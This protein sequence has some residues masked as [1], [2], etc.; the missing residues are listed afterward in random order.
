[1]SSSLA[2]VVPEEAA[3]IRGEWMATERRTYESAA[4]SGTGTGPFV[5]VADM[6]W[7][8][9]IECAVPVAGIAFLVTSREIYWAKSDPP[10]EN[11]PVE[12]AFHARAGYADGRATFA[13]SLGGSVLPGVPVAFG[14]DVS[15][16]CAFGPRRAVT[17][18]AH[19]V[20]QVENVAF[21]VVL[22][23]KSVIKIGRNHL[24]R[25]RDQLAASLPENA[26]RVLTR[27]RTGVLRG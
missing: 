2:A 10:A 20:A 13:A 26:R 4:Q 9:A 22:L 8:G 12:I 16:S 24:W 14:G 25:L 5:D 1:M 21:I 27:N 3:E 17:G 7:R 11:P 18:R 23:Q 15:A 19:L 6:R